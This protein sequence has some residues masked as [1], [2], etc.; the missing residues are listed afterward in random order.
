MFLDFC[1]AVRAEMLVMQR[2]DGF[3]HR[4]R[5]SRRMSEHVLHV[6]N[7]QMCRCKGT[8]NFQSIPECQSVA[9]AVYYNRSLAIYFSCEQSF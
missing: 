3:T 1:I 8:I 2:V 6:C 9:V 4:P 5:H 7:R